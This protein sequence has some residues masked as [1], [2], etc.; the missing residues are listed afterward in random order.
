MKADLSQQIH[1]M[2]KRMILYNII[3]TL[4]ENK[5]LSSALEL[6]FEMI[7]LIKLM[8]QI[9][10]LSYGRLWDKGNLTSFLQG[11]DSNLKNRFYFFNNH[12]AI[13]KFK[14]V[15]EHCLV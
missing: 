1:V 4:R 6:C 2:L 14:M 11:K 8:G 10:E 3:R 9:I 7:K 12:S 15:P 5:K 13:F